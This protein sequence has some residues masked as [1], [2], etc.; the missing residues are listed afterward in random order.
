MQAGGSGSNT[1]FEW[2]REFIMNLNSQR[3]ILTTNEPCST[4]N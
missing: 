3:F 4:I 1:I 2:L